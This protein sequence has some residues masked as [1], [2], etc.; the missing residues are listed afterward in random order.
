MQITYKN[1]YTTDIK[2]NSFELNLTFDGYQIDGYHLT[3]SDGYFT[4]AS[5]THY[6]PETE[7]VIPVPFPN[8]VNIYA[9]LD[10]NNNNEPCILV[11]EILPG[12]SP[13]TFKDSTHYKLLD[14][15]ARIS[16]KDLENQQISFLRIILNPSQP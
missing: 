12:H 15:L 5:E 16:K 4:L 10:L 7:I 2:I 8:A 6:V 1:V 13:F 9:C 3:I 11:D 14:S